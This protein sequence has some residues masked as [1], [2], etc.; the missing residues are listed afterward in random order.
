MAL[1]A[2]VLTIHFLTVS[3]I[4]STRFLASYLYQHPPPSLKIDSDSFIQLEHSSGLP[5]N[6]VD[7]SLYLQQLVLALLISVPARISSYHSTAYSNLTTTSKV[8]RHSIHQQLLDIHQVLI[9]MESHY[10]SFQLHIHSTVSP[11]P[12]SLHLAP[13]SSHAI[14]ICFM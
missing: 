7:S 10:H 11:L 14:I 12:L 6:W 13:Y 9:K 3:L 8:P 5:S 1:A 4:L 2:C